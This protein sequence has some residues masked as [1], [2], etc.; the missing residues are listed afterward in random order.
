VGTPREKA[1][2]HLARV[3]QCPSWAKHI[4]QVELT[5]PGEL[6]PESTGRIRLSKPGMEPESVERLDRAGIAAARCR[7]RGGKA[8]MA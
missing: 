1:W 5:P 3:E 6:G 7:A 4:K 2:Q 8:D